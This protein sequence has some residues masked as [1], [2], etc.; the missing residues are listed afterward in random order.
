MYHATIQ[1]FLPLQVQEL[2]LHPAYQEDRGTTILIKKFMALPFLPSREIPDTFARLEAKATTAPLQMFANYVKD[3]W[4]D[5]QVMPPSCWSVFKEAVRT[6]NDIEG[7]H[8]GLNRRAEGKTQLPL[9]LLIHLLHQEARLTS[10]QIRLVSERKLKRVQRKTYRMLQ[11]KIFKLWEEYE[12]GE[13]SV[14]R[15]LKACTNLV[16]P[17]GLSN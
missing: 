8:H 7:W 10:L 6:N 5:S 12:A 16:G 9:Y 11:S 2:G 4:I 15:L 17:S 14:K 1:V 13:R 3:T